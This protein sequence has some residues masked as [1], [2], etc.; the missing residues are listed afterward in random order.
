MSPPLQ[1]SPNSHL[2]TS[3]SLHCGQ[4][5]D[6]Y[7]L[8]EQQSPFPKQ[9]V[10]ISTRSQDNPTALTSA[11]CPGTKVLQ[12][13]WLMVSPI[14]LQYGSRSSDSGGCSFYSPT[15]SGGSWENLISLLFREPLMITAHAP[16]I[17]IWPTDTFHHIKCVS[18]VTL[19]LVLLRKI[20]T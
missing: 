5:G 18:C 13:R 17:L 7:W 14:L 6:I 4:A 2:G 9:P 15:F 3:E 11:L 8:Q 12:T 10:R 20:V 16:G 19:R 1:S